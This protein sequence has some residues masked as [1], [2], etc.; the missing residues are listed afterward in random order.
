MYI[1]TAEKK[2]YCRK[3]GNI[4]FV[5]G[6][7]ETKDAWLASWFSGRAGFSVTASAS[8]PDSVSE[9]D[10]HEM[11]LTELRAAC[12]ALGLTGYSGLKKDEL[13]QLLENSG[14][15]DDGNR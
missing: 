2:D 10:I 12:E 7:A 11:N 8:K 15:E 6:V 5:N 4:Q 13:I 3:V 1:I 14:G 9:R